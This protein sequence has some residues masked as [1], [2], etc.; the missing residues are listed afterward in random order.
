MVRHPAS[1][2]CNTA[3][4]G[5]TLFMDCDVSGPAQIRYKWS[6]KAV[7]HEEWTKRQTEAGEDVQPCLTEQGLR[8]ARQGR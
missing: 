6:G 8:C 1:G 3:R 5:E 2:K 7:S 4:E